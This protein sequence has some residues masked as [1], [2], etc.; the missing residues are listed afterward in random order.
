MPDPRC[1][2]LL[3]VMVFHTWSAAVTVRAFLPR[4]TESDASLGFG[5]LFPW[6]ATSMRAVVIFVTLFPVLIL[7]KADLYGV[8]RPCTV[9][10]NRWCSAISPSFYFV[11]HSFKRARFPYY[12][13]YYCY[14]HNFGPYVG[15]HVCSQC[16]PDNQTD[17]HYF[18]VFLRL[19]VTDLGSGY[20]LPR[21]NER[22][23]YVFFASLVVSVVYGFLQK[24]GHRTLLHYSSISVC[25]YSACALTSCEG[26]FKD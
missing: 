12:L 11:L 5:L 24:V 26:P 9:V 13:A 2:H 23:V 17:S 16:Q 21:L 1:G 10:A 7:R 3:F 19:Q 6:S 18:T 4:Q 15:V 22:F 8:F 14:L 25:P 20:E